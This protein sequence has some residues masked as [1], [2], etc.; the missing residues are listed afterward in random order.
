MQTGFEQTY[1]RSKGKGMGKLTQLDNSNGI[2]KVN[3]VRMLL[4]LKI[5]KKTELHHLEWGGGIVTMHLLHSN[6]YLFLFLLLILNKVVPS[7]RSL[8]FH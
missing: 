7:I 6:M 5:Q 3:R 1:N 8:S 2:V 4:N